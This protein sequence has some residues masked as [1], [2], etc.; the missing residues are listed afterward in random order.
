MQQDTDLNGEGGDVLV[1]LAPADWAAADDIRRRRFARVNEGYDTEE[2]HEYLGML[3]S[4]FANLRQQVTELRNAQGSGEASGDA[5]VS[6][7]ATKMADMLREAEEHAAQVRDGAQAEVAR[8][9]EEAE[10]EGSKVLAEARQ[11][12]DR[13][14]NEAR[15]EADRTVVAA[16][17]ESEQ[18]SSTYLA[19]ATKAK[20]EAEEEAARVLAAARDEAERLRS[21]ASH[22]TTQ[23]REQADRA[24]ADSAALRAAVLAEL[25]GAFERIGA[26]APVADPGAP[27]AVDP[28]AR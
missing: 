1:N 25:Q 28:A 19:D 20:S 13:L 17:K 3:A 18:A 24:V 10:R 16:R 14:L 22:A 15:Q 4:M 11:E 21:E 6:G 12:A 7:L 27:K 26:L 8:A 23:A 5:P 9:K 2:V